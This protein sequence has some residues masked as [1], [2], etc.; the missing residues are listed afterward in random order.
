MFVFPRKTDKAQNQLRGMVMA[1][2]A[3]TQKGYRADRA[4]TPGRTYGCGSVL[5]FEQLLTEPTVPR[6][7]WD[8]LSPGGL[9][10]GAGWGGSFC[11]SLSMAVQS[12]GHHRHCSERP[13]N[14]LACKLGK[15]NQ[16]SPSSS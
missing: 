12:Q 7:W 11:L 3:I 2:G 5:R 4:E 6:A 14:W 15:R 10:E 9:S 16:Q 1:A 8:A 13:L